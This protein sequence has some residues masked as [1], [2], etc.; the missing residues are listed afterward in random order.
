MATYCRS[1][2]LD[3]GRGR[4]G[5]VGGR[6]GKIVS[7]REGEGLVGEGKGGGGASGGRGR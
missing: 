6:E 5:L 7:G 1:R 2:E 4:E 3:E